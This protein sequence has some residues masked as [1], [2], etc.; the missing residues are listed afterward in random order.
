MK[1]LRKKRYLEKLELIQK[2]AEEIDSWKTGFFLE[3]KDKLAV[4]KAFQEIAEAI[5]DVI[6]MMLKDEDKVTADDYTNT[7]KAVDFKLLPK[8]LKNSIDELNGLRNRII[9]EY[10]GLDDHIAFNSIEEIMPEIKKITE[11]IKKWIG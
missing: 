3:E 6:S 1:E 5:M 2:R 7:E 4:Y 9:H 8:K 11:A 10:N